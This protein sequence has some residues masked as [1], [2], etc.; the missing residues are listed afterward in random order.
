MIN[1]YK[2]I[3]LVFK[4]YIYIFFCKFIIIFDLDFRMCEVI[5][6]YIF[7]LMLNYNM[8]DGLEIFYKY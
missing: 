3:I 5:R 6:V 7:C 8:C 4:F 1:Y 2:Y